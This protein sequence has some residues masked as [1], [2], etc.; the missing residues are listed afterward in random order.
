MTTLVTI[1][2]DSTGTSGDDHIIDVDGPGEKKMLRPGESTTIHV[3]QGVSIVIQEVNVPE[4]KKED[5]TEIFGIEVK[6]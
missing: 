3:W 5:G 1:K 6:S 4:A 2:N